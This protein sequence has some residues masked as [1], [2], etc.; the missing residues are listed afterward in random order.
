MRHE[1]TI[2]FNTIATQVSD[3]GS[4][5]RIMAARVNEPARVN[6]APSGMQRVPARL[7]CEG[8]SYYWTS[9]YH[10]Y[11]RIA[12]AFDSIRYCGND[13]FVPE[14]VVKEET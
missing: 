11:C 1:T 7:G 12:Y 3:P 8:C 2:N 14:T 6:E 5:A 10:G 4:L 13:I 9:K